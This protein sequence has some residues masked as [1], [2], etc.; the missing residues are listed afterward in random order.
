MGETYL[1]VFC[2]G[3]LTNS[4]KVKINPKNPRFGTL[5]LARDRTR[6]DSGII[7]LAFCSSPRYPGHRRLGLLAVGFFGG[8]ELRKTPISNP[9]FFPDCS[10]GTRGST[11]R[12]IGDRRVFKRTVRKLGKCTKYVVNE[13]G[14]KKSRSPRSQPSGAGCGI[15]WID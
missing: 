4:A 11:S 8:F 10:C 6:R 15:I 14:A 2:F 9:I 13:S 5:V 7:S 12:G 3:I 1:F